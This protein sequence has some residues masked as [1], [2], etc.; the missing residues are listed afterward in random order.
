M[1]NCPTRVTET[2]ESMIDL[3]FISTPDIL[4]KVGCAEV[5]LSD[6]ELIYGTISRS[7]QK[8]EQKCFSI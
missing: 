8:Q 1:I 7:L 3:M 4:K 6:H 5:A 2:S